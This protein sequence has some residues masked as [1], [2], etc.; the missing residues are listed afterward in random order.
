MDVYSNVIVEKV[1]FEAEAT[2]DC[3]DYLETKGFLTVTHHKPTGVHY[4]LIRITSKGVE[5]IE[6]FR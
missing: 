4:N 2:M 5:E 3:I 6:K 1:D